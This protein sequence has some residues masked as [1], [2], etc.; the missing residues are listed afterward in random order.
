LK[1]VAIHAPTVPRKLKTVPIGP[2]AGGKVSGLGASRTMK[3]TSARTNTGC[4]ATTSP[5]G[6]TG[7]RENTITKV[8]R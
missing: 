3:V 2:L 1:G 7:R 4:T 5:C 6:M 8:A